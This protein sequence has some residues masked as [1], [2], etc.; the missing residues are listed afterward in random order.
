MAELWVEAQMAQLRSRGMVDLT[1]PW[2]ADRFPAAADA[3]PSRAIQVG[4]PDEQGENRFNVI[5]KPR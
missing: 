3:T 4:N 5:A 2:C 1:M